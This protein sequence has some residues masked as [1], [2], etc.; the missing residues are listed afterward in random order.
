MNLTNIKT[1][2]REPETGVCHRFAVNPTEDDAYR[3]LLQT[4]T[5]TLS[6]KA[7]RTVKLILTSNQTAD[8]GAFTS[9]INALK[10]FRL[11]R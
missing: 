10:L 5:A 3:F 4:T 8:T 9:Q 11:N 7:R 2:K 6:V 1:I